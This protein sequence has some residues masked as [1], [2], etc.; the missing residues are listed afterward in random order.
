M[1][2]APL[3]GIVPLAECDP[4]FFTQLGTEVLTHYDSHMI[5]SALDVVLGQVMRYVQITVGYPKQL[6]ESRGQYLHQLLGRQG[7]EGIL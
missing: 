5:E 6:D 4:V 7:R 2:R 3:C 1:V